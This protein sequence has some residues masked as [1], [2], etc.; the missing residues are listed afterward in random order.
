[1]RHIQNDK[2]GDEQLLPV[3]VMAAAVLVCITLLS[4]GIANAIQ[5]N[6]PTGY[7]QDIEGYDIFGGVEYNFCEPV[8]G[9]NVSM[10]NHTQNAESDNPIKKLEFDYDPFDFMT[11]RLVRDFDNLGPYHTRYHYN[12]FINIHVKKGGVTWGKDRWVQI[13]YDG[14]LRTSFAYVNETE[15]CSFAYFEAFNSNF[16]VVLTT[17]TNDSSAHYGSIMAGTYNLKIAY[18]AENDMSM[19]QSMWTILGQILTLELP[20]MGNEANLLFAVPIWA[21]LGFMVFT[22]LSRVIPFISGG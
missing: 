13:P 1:M 16:T 12:D 15:T 8:Y 17:W 7:W 22:I 18:N 20:D 10:A 21:A 11:V 6:T 14:A 3:F 9:F 5:R 2:D 19:H 4:T